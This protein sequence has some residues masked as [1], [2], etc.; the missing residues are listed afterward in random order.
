MLR[1][2]IAP[3]PRIRG[4]RVD[5]P[6]RRLLENDRLEL[7]V[8]AEASG[9]ARATVELAAPERLEPELAALGVRC[10][11]CA[12]AVLRVRARRWG[13][14][15]LGALT[16]RTVDRAG[17]RSATS[18]VR[19]TGAVRVLPEAPR[20]TSL[21][22]AARTQARAGTQ[23]SR[24]RGEGTELAELRP[25]RPGD[26]RRRV[27]WRA[28]ARRGRLV[29][30]DR[31]ADRNADVVL[32]LDTFAEARHGAQGTLGAAVRAAAGI[33]E[34]HLARMDRVAVVGFGGLLHWLPP[35][36]GA[37]AR[38]RILDALV[39]SEAMTSYAAKDVAT[40]PP[41][42]LPARSLV[43]ALSPLLDPRGI[44]AL[45]DL[46]ARGFDVVLLDVS[47]E[48]YLAPAATPEERLGRRLWRLHRAALRTGLQRAG[49]A[50]TTV[51]EDTQL[52]AAIEEVT[53]WRR[54]AARSAPPPR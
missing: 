4:V 14:T 26:P 17:L 46:R 40:I 19:D 52:T 20:L 5:V 32:L 21:F 48:P 36:M 42:V 1:G 18:L 10:A 35:T 33:A 37:A 34:A 3:A 29:A 43:V 7:R 9:A 6:V 39:D 41:R 27:A 15:R 53:R 13:R 25:L 12:T 31:H 23:L 2:L 54:Y 30:A 38:Y 28:S 11:P 47:P 50:V 44:A 49:I 45:L 8:E 24:E 51:A 22:E 16:V